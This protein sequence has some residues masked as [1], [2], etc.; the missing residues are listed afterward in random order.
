MVKVWGV[1][2]G[3]THMLGLVRGFFLRPDAVRSV[4]YSTLATLISKSVGSRR[5]HSSNFKFRS[6]CLTVAPA[7]SPCFNSSVSR[8]SAEGPEG[9]HCYDV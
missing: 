9:H 8:Q 3:E 7:C 4:V 5:D 2:Q 1:A 6:L